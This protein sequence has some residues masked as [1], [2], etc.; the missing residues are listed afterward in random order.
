MLINDL[1]TLKAQIGGVQK[2][3]NWQTWEPHVRQSEIKYIIPAIGQ[4]LYDE[5][6]AVVSPANPQ[7][8]LLDRLRAATAYFAYLEA[9]PFLMVATG[10]AGLM[11]N[12][13]S[14][15]QILTKWMY[16]GVL[17]DVQAKADFWLENAIQWLETHA[18]QY[19][20]WTNSGLYTISQGH[21]IPSATIWT[22]VFPSA[23]NSRRLFL[24]VRQYLFNTEESI[25]QTLLGSDFYEALLN[26][27]KT[28]GNVFTVKE[29]NVLRLCRVFVANAGFAKALPFLNLNA[30][31][32]LVSETDGIV[33][34]DEL[35]TERLNILLRECQ[36]TADKAAGEL[37]DFLNANA[38][39]LIF[40]EWF[41][42]ER[43]R[44]PVSPKR[45]GFPNDPKNKAFVLR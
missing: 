33:N 20:I 36:E 43:Y 25:L 21:F 19:P 44:T 41:N 15:T 23:Q 10:D 38:S 22:T 45:L 27:L 12:S 17:K 30:D 28:T 2:S 24:S 13:P 29:A 26:R 4:E 3:M 5:L 31:F 14:N 11:V 37:T 7:K 35:P 1:P 34:E 16:V 6:I 8:P 9:M 32:R 42:S 18:A 39:S 40:P